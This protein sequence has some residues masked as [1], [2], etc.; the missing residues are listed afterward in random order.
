MTYFVSHPTSLTLCTSVSLNDTVATHLEAQSNTTT[1]LL[2]FYL[3]SICSF[4]RP[5][6][7]R[8]ELT[9][10]QGPFLSL[11]RASAIQTVSIWYND[12]SSLA[13]GPLAQLQPLFHSQSS[14]CTVLQCPVPAMQLHGVPRMTFLTARTP[15]EI[16]I[17]GQASSITVIWGLSFDAIPRN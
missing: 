7:R 8:M 6:R 1:V 11:A 4:P 16:E 3:C 5:I 9:L 2:L 13:I 14:Y 17:P 12:R 10:L 15:P